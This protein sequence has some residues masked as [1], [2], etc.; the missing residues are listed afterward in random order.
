MDFI[1]E[2]TYEVWIRTARDSKEKMGVYKIYSHLPI[3]E[4]QKALESRYVGE[5]DVYILQYR[6]VP[7][8]GEITHS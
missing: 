1:R 5:I 2:I 3:P 6:A 7:F 4:A 8:L